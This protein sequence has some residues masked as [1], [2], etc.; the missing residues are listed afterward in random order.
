[1]DFEVGFKELKRQLAEKAFKKG[2]WKGLAL[3]P[4]EFGAE[5]GCEV[6]FAFVDDAAAEGGGFY[7]ELCAD[8]HHQGFVVKADAVDVGT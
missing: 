7:C 6:V 5:D 2:N 1:M 8:F 3:A 4:V